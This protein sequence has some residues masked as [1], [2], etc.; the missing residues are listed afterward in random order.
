MTPI[1][2]RTFF[3]LGAT[4]ALV[5]PVAGLGQGAASAQGT[6]LSDPSAVH[7]YDERVDAAPVL[8]GDGVVASL[9][10]PAYSRG[11]AAHGAMGWLSAAE[12]GG[13]RL[14]YANPAPASSSGSVYLTPR[15]LAPSATATVVALLN[16]VDATSLAAKV[17]LTADGRVE[18]LDST[19][20]RMALSKPVW[21]LA[22]KMR[23]DWQQDWADGVLVLQ[24]RVFARGGAEGWRPDAVLEATFPFGS[25][26]YVAL[27][28]D[29]NVQASIGFD[30]YREYAFAAVPAPFAPVVG[31][32]AMHSYD[33]GVEGAALRAGANMVTGVS[34]RP[35][36]AAAAA[37][38]GAFGVVLPATGAG[39]LRYD[40]P[41]APRHTGSVYVRTILRGAGN[42]RIVTLQSGSTVLAQVKLTSRGA[43]CI[44]DAQGVLLSQ[45]AS[46]GQLKSWAR[47][48]WQCAWDGTALALTARYFSTDA[49]SVDNYTEISATLPAVTTPDTVAVGSGA[50]GWKLYVDSVRTYG[51]I[52]AWP[53]PVNPVGVVRAPGM[54]AWAGDATQSSVELA[55]YTNDTTCVGL[56]TSANPDM[57]D[58]TSWPAA[59]P[60]AVGWN[61][62]SLTG[63]AA[64]TRYYHQLSDTPPESPSTLIGDVSTFTTLQPTGV[65]CTTRIAVGSC[66]Q[67]APMNG[68]AFDDIVA[69]A[70]D[71]TVHLGDFG[72]PNDL[73]R[74]PS[75]HMNNWSLNCTDAGIRR[76]QAIGCMD[77]VISDHDV[78]G[79]GN[80]NLPTYNDPV[81]MA[82]LIAWQQVVP[83]RME[84]TQSPPHGRW[85]SDV[86]GSVRYVKVDT[87][88]IDKTDT[89][90]TPTDPGSPS[91][92]MLGATQLAWLKGQI[93]AAVGARQLVVI[94]SD[95][96]WNG[97][98]P[99][100]PI[101]VSYSDKWP[102]Y[103]YERDLVSDYAASAGAQ[104][105]IVFGDSHG[106]QQDDGTHEKNGFAS[107]CCGPFD[108]ELHMHYQDSYQWSYPDGILDEGAPYRVAQQYQRLTISQ[109][110]G[111]STITLTAEARDCSP[112]VVGTPL[113][114]ATLTK[115]FTL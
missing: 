53:T 67:T 8:V 44:A 84:D 92:T 49:E 15:A 80:S 108:Q 55:A 97:T 51:D 42:S 86:E 10:L 83:A 37:K 91:S 82:N 31:A 11:D 102:S 13:G 14:V 113:T 47:I 62:W 6:A 95:C 104:L 70:P 40:N 90:G 39:V 29:A 25:P 21:S 57:S 101:P 43:L 87:R 17:R 9:G 32:V 111:S 60:N 35:K 58:P 46:R 54:A 24:V 4:S 27:G 48:D 77:Y 98:S 99:G 61:K 3:R 52:S 72:Y 30:T 109:E 105:F 28:Q 78:N 110:V 64:G 38:H 71:R 107:I 112:A 88:S 19:D 66:G 68:A 26:S 106:L 96:A 100:P 65:G 73:S 79:T 1:N 115:T 20:L 18:L 23:L 36:Y 94:F 89:T 34:G 41:Y 63:L 2:R 85:R 114:V 56:V 5:P 16:D 75:T 7:T 33:E 69:W 74:D 103:T 93:D 45:S 12:T 76:I 50:M 81:T 22:E 59:P